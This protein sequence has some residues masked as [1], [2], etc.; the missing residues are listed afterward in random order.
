MKVRVFPSFRTKLLNQLVFIA[1]DKPG[2]ARKFRSDIFDEIKKLSLMP[3][4]NR[5]SIFFEESSVRDLI[6][7]G[8]VIVYNINEL[9][10][11]I[12]VFGF[13]KYVEKP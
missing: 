9:K 13:I 6:F 5:Q 1:Q 8:Y 4:K 3:Y 12:E 10:G 7:K 2:A 11:E